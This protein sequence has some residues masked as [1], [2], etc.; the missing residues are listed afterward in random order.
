VPGLG[1]LP[2]AHQLD[3]EAELAFEMLRQY[4]MIAP[5]EENVA[6]GCDWMGLGQRAAIAD[7]ALMIVPQSPSMI[8]GL[9][10]VMRWPDGDNHL[11]TIENELVALIAT[12]GVPEEES[13]QSDD[14]KTHRSQEQMAL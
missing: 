11:S 12:L 7:H 14:D 9:E 10:R 8:F 4:L 13:Y 2:L 1:Q 3:W 6:R 5:E